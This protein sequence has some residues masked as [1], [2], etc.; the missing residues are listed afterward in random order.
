MNYLVY[1]AC[2][3]TLACHDERGCSGSGKSSCSC[4]LN[5]ADALDAAV[6]EAR[7]DAWSPRLPDAGKREAT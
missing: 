5:A 1:C 3:H 4:R 2:S 6:K 7:R